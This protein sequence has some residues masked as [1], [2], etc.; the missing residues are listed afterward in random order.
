M[1][2]EEILFECYL[3]FLKQFNFTNSVQLWLTIA[4]DFN[5]YL[6]NDFH[7]IIWQD[8]ILAIGSTVFRTLVLM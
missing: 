7:L 1:N 4:L 8:I 6:S 2:Y 3:K 5:S